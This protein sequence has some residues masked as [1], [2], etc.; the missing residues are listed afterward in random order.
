MASLVCR[1]ESV[2]FVLQDARLSQLLSRHYPLVLCL[3][4]LPVM[5]HRVAFLRLGPEVR[6]REAVVEVRAEVVHE[7]N[8]EHDIHAKLQRARTCVSTEVTIGHALYIS[9]PYL[10]D[11][12]VEAGHLC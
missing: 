3:E 6:D 9:M 4:L 8:R 10:E 7:A 5:R 1:G 12:E 11:F 2:S